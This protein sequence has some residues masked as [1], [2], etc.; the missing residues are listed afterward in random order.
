[1]IVDLSAGCRQDK[2]VVRFTAYQEPRL[3]V[4][5]QLA[6]F[7]P[8]PDFPVEYIRIN[9]ILD[10]GSRPRFGDDSQI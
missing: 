10:V 8:T 1:M 4:G 9:E 6:K 7:S 2:S 3:R 5:V